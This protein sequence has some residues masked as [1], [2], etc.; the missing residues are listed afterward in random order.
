MEGKTWEFIV[1]VESPILLDD[2]E[3][4]V[5]EGEGLHFPLS[6]AYE[7]NLVNAHW[8]AFVKDM[9]R[10]K[11]ED[12]K[13]AL[14]A[15]EQDDRTAFDRS[16]VHIAGISSMYRLNDASISDGRNLILI[17]GMTDFKDY[18]GTT[19]HALKDEAF[20]EMLMKAGIADFNDPNHYFSNP[21]ATCSNIVT[22]DGKIPIGMRS[23][24][25]AI[26]PGVPHIIGGYVKV[27]GDNKPDF[28]VKD[29]DI[30]ENMRK[31]LKQE[32]GLG[33]KD[34]VGVDFLG[35]V[36]NRITRG[37]EALY[38]VRINITAEEL[39]ECWNTKSRDKYE[40]RN[41]TYHSKKELPRFLEEN[42]DKM[43]PSGEATLTIFLEH[44]KD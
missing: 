40:H 16:M 31:E 17:A 11:K 23:E 4:T 39:H 33:E 43:V 6:R 15:M 5:Q 18:I 38:N 9:A 13:I 36:R 30:F 14:A 19:Q 41:I 3:T 7:G 10:R 2:L 42:R 44:S 24:T 20:R 27:N 12:L 28:S 21:L 35:I 32:I 29:V 22:L 1:E 37:P 34:I 25:V 8:N 26:Y